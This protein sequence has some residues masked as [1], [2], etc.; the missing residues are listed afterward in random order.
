M[1][2][3]QRRV[4]VGKEADFNRRVFGSAVFSRNALVLFAA[5]INHRCPR[6]A[7][8]NFGERFS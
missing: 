5:G 7:L 4:F 8:S 2:K 6:E 3:M 1:R